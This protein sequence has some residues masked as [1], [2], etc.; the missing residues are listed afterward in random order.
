VSENAFGSS[1]TLSNVP[2]VAEKAQCL[3][4]S[5]A[6]ADSYSPG[7]TMQSS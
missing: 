3:I 4:L 5:N 2:L 6:R 1:I 7:M